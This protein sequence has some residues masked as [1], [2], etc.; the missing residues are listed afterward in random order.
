MRTERPACSERDSAASDCRAEALWSE[1]VSRSASEPE[2]ASL[3]QV[4]TARLPEEL[5][6]EIRC[7]GRV[8]QIE[9]S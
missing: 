3:N 2:S 1:P 7:E 9:V 6:P 5:K 4:R 8:A